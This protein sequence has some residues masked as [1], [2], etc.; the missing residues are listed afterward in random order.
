M[1]ITIAGKVSSD[2]KDRILA[3]EAVTRSI[4][5]RT[6][7]DPAEGV[8]ML[9]TAAAHLT[10]VYSKRPI[11]DTAEHLATALGHAIVAADGFFKLRA[12]PTT[13][14]QA[15]NDGGGNG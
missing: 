9:L 8:M 3:I 14:A 11:A 1:K 13:L 12:A 6:G 15:A 10:D 5:Q 2:P 4:C 7:Q